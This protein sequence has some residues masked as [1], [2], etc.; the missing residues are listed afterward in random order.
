MVRDSSSSFKIDYVMVIKDFLNPEGR[1]N[2]I[3]GSKIAAILLKGGFCLLVELQRGR[4]AQQVCFKTHII[5]NARSEYFVDLKV[6]Q[7]SLL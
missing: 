1:H 6:K 2:P 7:K 3:S 4:V 5:I